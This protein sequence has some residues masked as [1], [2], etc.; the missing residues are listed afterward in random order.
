MKMKRET[1]G[2]RFM[3]IQLNELTPFCL[4]ATLCCGQTFRWEKRGGWWYG[5]VKD[6]VFKIRQANN[7]LL[8]EN[9]DAGF[10]R[11]Y[12][13]LDDDLLNV[14]SRISKDEHVRKAVNAFRGLRILRQDPW[15]CLVSYVCATYKSIV[16][17]KQML[18]N[19]SKRFGEK[20]SFDGLDFY[21]FPT[22]EELA[23]ARLND[24]AKCGLGYRAKYVHETARI[25]NRSELKFEALKK[26]T[27]EEAKAEL[28]K[29]PGVGLK[30]A[31]C[32]LLFSLEKL[33]AF[34]IDVWVKRAITEH[35]S[36]HFPKEFISKTKNRRT[37]TSAEYKKME[38]FGQTYFG[39]CAGYAQEYLY[40][41]ER[42]HS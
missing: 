13:R 35:Y 42:T 3:N 8:F 21:A 2:V 1:S 33:E 19:L 27:Y 22:L 38:F 25:I 14:Y 30:V 36:G 40:H 20:I 23:R 10:V 32:V 7:Q 17:I 16:A 26:A 6:K 39:E 5:T 31:D 24:L 37:L 11:A 41:Y 15:E 34:P 29:L 28:M 12:F 4:D 9:V 18:F